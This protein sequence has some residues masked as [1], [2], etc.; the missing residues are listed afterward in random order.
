MQTEIELFNLKIL[1][2]HGFKMINVQKT[3]LK[4]PTRDFGQKH[5][6]GNFDSR[7]E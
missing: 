5:L 3:M 1:W 7:V 2:S 6:F 4:F